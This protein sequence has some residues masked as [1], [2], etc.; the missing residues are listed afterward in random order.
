MTF[1]SISVP[2]DYGN[3][4]ITILTFNPTTTRV[5]VVI[6]IVDD[7]SDELVENFFARLILISASADDVVL[8]PDETGIVIND[9]DGKLNLISEYLGV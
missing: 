4:D 7:E 5:P 3:P 6:P 1:S 8:Q 9:N 2:D